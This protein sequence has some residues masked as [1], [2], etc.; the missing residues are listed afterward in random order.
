MPSRP[1][2]FFLQYAGDIIALGTYRNTMH[3]RHMA[4][5]VGSKGRDAVLTAMA[6]VIRQF[7][8][9][10]FSLMPFTHIDG[11]KS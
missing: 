8:F 5:L 10:I 7:F 2:V 4:S 3:P 11:I 9:D 1:C 6:K